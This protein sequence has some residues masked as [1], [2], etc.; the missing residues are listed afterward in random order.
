MI[1]KDGHV[2]LA[3]FGLSKQGLRDL[4]RSTMEIQKGPNSG[5]RRSVQLDFRRRSQSFLK[6]RRELVHTFAQSLLTNVK[7]YSVVGSPDYMAY[8][9]L[10][11]DGY[12]FSVDWW[13]LG[14]HS[15]ALSLQMTPRSH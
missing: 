15:S 1:D 9:L 7:H 13:S 6:H 4:Y 14:T 8:E 5:L 10:M 2:K 12:D 3:D 11:G